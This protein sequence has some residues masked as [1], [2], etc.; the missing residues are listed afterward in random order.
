MQQKQTILVIDDDRI[1]LDIM[2]NVLFTAGYRVLIAED[3]ETG[4]HRAIFA[5][6]DLILLDI[7]MPGADGYETCIMLKGNKRTQHIP[8]FFKTCKGDTESIAAGYLTGADSFIIKPCNHDRLLREIKS[9]L[10]LDRLNLL[11]QHLQSL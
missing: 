8:I 10:A 9:R 7:M 6:P 3:G 1:E 5:K 2:S 4:Y 11:Q